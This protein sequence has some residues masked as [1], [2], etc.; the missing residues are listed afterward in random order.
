MGM[1]GSKLKERLNQLSSRNDALT[2]RI[3]ILE[4]ERRLL[5]VRNDA[6]QKQLVSIIGRLG[7]ATASRNRFEREAKKFRHLFGKA[8]D[9]LR[10]LIEEIDALVENSC[11]VMGI[12]PNGDLAPWT[13][14]LL[15]REFNGWLPSVH[16]THGILEE[17]DKK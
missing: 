5:E 9:A 3:D 11:G 17:L 2:H 16:E 14:L 4:T 7:A 13:E 6:L 15:G 12:H 1:F 8:R 10:T